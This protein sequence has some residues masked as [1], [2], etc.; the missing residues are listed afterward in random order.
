VNA[1]VEKINPVQHRITCQIAAQVVDQAFNSAYR[2]IQKRVKLD[3]FRPGKA[4]LTIIKKY[5]GQNVVG[6]VTEKLIQDSLYHALAEN[7]IAPVASPVVDAK[8]PPQ[9]GVDYAFSALVDVM[10]EIEIKNY[11]GLE[12][13]CEKHVLSPEAVENEIARLQ[14]R[15]AKLQ[16]IAEGT[17]AASGNAALIS[18][19]AE[20]D[21]KK[22]EQLEVEKV[23]VHLGSGDL[24]QQLEAGILSMA[25]GQ[26]KSFPVDLPADYPD[27][28]FAGKALNFT[29][30]L[31]ELND[32]ILPEL[33]DEFAKDLEF[34]TMDALRVGVKER[35]EKQVVDMHRQRLEELC[36]QKLSADNPFEVPPSMVD[37]VIDSMIESAYSRSP[38]AKQKQ[39]A[40][41]DE[42]LRKSLRE[43]AKSRARN[44]LILWKIAQDEKLETTDDEIRARVDE[45]LGGMGAGAANDKFIKDARARLSRQIRDNI[46]FEKA[47][48]LIIKAAKVTDLPP[49]AE[50]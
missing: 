17:L 3:G 40:M 41:H 8:E 39:A 19:S 28:E 11:N 2:K 24:Q 7:K 31:H 46:V 32:V 36:L 4:P 49:S 13:S 1:T 48:D 27:A 25:S 50:K 37:Q 33:S 12:I 20:L 42:E 35:M 47:L 44:T 30:T 34:E 26:T 18:H 38:D 6:E 5:Y 14:K 43:E 45:I 16:P 21:G 22:V 9:M 10:P 29:V 15:A 23:R